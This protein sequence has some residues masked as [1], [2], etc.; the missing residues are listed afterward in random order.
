[1]L[2]GLSVTIGTKPQ[3]PPIELRTVNV[4]QS[5]A[6]LRMGIGFHIRLILWFL[7][8]SVYYIGSMSLGPSRNTAAQ[9]FPVHPLSKLWG[10]LALSSISHGPH[11]SSIGS[12][13]SK[14]C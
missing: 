11:P 2:P 14:Q 12:D 10:F 1:M 3:S 7:T 9:I 4:M 8:K 13:S 5:R 6:R